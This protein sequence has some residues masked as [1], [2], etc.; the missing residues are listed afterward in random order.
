MSSLNYADF[1]KVKFKGSIS[2]FLLFAY[3]QKHSGND[4]FYRE[5]QC[6]LWKLFI[7]QDLAAIRKNIYGRTTNSKISG[8]FYKEVFKTAYFKI[9]LQE[10]LFCKKEASLTKTI[11]ID[12]S[13]FLESF[14]DFKVSL[15]DINLGSS[16]C[17]CFLGRYNSL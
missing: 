14:L 16:N 11:V 17:G 8:V 15:L 5:L 1:R 7:L 10:P 12:I 6:F 4:I 13:F 2:Y 9:V 3:L